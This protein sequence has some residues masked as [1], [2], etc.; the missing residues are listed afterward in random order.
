MGK[1]VE[2]DYMRMRTYNEYRILYHIRIINKR[3][4]I[5]ALKTLIK[6]QRTHNLKQYTITLN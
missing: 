5:R 6:E 1:K 2:G 3:E 4:Y